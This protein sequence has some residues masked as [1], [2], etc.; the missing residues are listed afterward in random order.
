VLPPL[1]QAQATIAHFQDLASFYATRSPA[2]AQ[3]YQ[4][5]A[6][7][8][9]LNVG[10]LATAA[11]TSG[12]R[13]DLAEAQTK[14]IAS[15]DA[16]ARDI[17]K[18]HDAASVQ[19]AT[20]E[21]SSRMELA[22]YNGAERQALARLTGAYHLQGISWEAASRQAIDEYNQGMSNYR[23]AQF[24]QQFNPAAT[25]PPQ[26]IYQPPVFNINVPGAGGGGPA[27]PGSNPAPNPP[28]G[29]A[30]GGLSPQA[31]NVLTG[32]QAALKRGASL[33]DVLDALQKN[34]GPAGLTAQDVQAVRAALS[35]GLK[36]LPVG[37]M[38]G[39]LAPV[40]PTGGGSTAI[41]PFPLAH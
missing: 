23:S 37:G 10:T 35:G 26:P 24:E 3:F 6:R 25:L 22:R 30:G 9:A 17:A 31:Q 21:A 32:A 1:Q 5:Q 28:G 34:A 18:G 7:D 15:L 38:R 36:P 12:A 20:A 41:D 2:A 8:A 19:R 14:N 39:A 4:Q 16:R 29:G 33:H 27:F 40:R 13:T 11:Y